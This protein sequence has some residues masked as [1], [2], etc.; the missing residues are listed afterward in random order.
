MTPS[1]DPVLTRWSPVC[2]A[3][4]RLLSPHAEV[5]MHDPDTD[6][7]MGI[8]NAFSGRIPGSPSLLGELDGVAGSA[9]GVYG[10]YEKV[11]PDG[12]RLSSVSAVVRDDDG[13][14]CAVLC[15]NLDRSPFTQVAALL[16]GF[17]APRADRPEVLFDNDWV[18]RVNQTVGA[19]VQELGRPVARWTRQ[20][21]IAVLSELD[22]LGVFSVRRAIPV[23]AG[24][25]SISRST[26][27]S[28]LAEARARR[29]AS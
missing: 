17:A 7:I 29:G 21:R 26:V 6:R 28:L 4:A 11:L 12:R 19:Y 5:V 13:R 27:Y 15:V 10:P 16:A 20:D 3:I 23:V 9:D 1:L 2:E 24:A 18:E 25:L 22:G 14:A 8:W